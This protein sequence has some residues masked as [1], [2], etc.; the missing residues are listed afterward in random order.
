MEKQ[1]IIKYAVDSL[2]K[3]GVKPM[4][5]FEINDGGQLC[6]ARGYVSSIYLTRDLEVVSIVKWTDK[7]TLI[8]DTIDLDTVESIADEK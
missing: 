5:R 4:S 7:G 8:T 1:D 3:V 6:S 2:N